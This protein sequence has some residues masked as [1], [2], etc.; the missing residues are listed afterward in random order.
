MKMQIVLRWRRGG[1]TH[2]R[3]AG[4]A[5]PRH[6]S[7]DLPAAAYPEKSIRFL[8]ANAPGGGLDVTARMTGPVVSSALGQQLIYD[9][10]AGATGSLAAETVARSA[11]DG[12]TMMV[13]S[14]GNLAVNPHLY[15]GLGYDPIRDL[16]PVTFAVSGSNVLV[17]Q[18]S[19]PIK[20]VQDL[21]AYARK[22]PGGAHVRIDRQ[23]KCRASRGGAL[24]QHDENE[25][26]PR[27]LQ[28]RRACDGRNAFQARFS[29]FLRPPR[30]G[31]GQSKPER[32]GRLQ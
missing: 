16:A 1:S 14:I 9:N 23:R 15:K 26:G 22:Q 10:R 21:I 5:Q 7:A 32:S 27:A 3:N 20:S 11:P 24:L 2:I 28:G 25:D 12:Y 19:L 31:S 6:S 17:V 8:I 30:R 18:P 29:S 13:G 4:L